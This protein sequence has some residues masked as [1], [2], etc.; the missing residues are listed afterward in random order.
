MAAERAGGV[1]EEKVEA[2]AALFE[3]GWE[4][5]MGDWEGGSRWRYCVAGWGGTGHH[6]KHL[7]PGPSLVAGSAV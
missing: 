4:E 1:S 5:R 2:E 6:K 3:D 7:K